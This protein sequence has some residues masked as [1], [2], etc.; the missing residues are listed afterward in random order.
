MVAI[1]LSARLRTGNEMLLGWQADACAIDLGANLAVP[2]ENQP[3][4][5]D[6]FPGGR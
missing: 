5:G 1:Q 2:V 3:L 6:A 4:S